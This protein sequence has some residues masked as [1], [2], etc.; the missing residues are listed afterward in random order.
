MNYYGDPLNRLIEELGRLPGIGAKSAQRLA[1]YLINQPEER[2]TSLA[3]AITDAKKNI[4]YCGVC[5][6]ITDADP[7]A[8]CSDPKREKPPSWWSKTRATWP[9][10]SARTNTGACTTSSTAPYPP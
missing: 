2:A 3:A 6:N 4:R 8:A 10:T 1:F 7:C 9:R 5:C